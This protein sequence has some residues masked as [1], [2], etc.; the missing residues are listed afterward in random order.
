MKFEIYRTNH[1]FQ[2]TLNKQEEGI[3]HSISEIA[4][5]IVDLKKSLDSNDVCLVSE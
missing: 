2:T 1:E 4:K 3:N 5:S